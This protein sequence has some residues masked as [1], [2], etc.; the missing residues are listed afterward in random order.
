MAFSQTITTGDR[1][2]EPMIELARCSKQQ[3]IVIAGDK[4][5]E[6]MLELKNR[7]FLHVYGQANCGLPAGQ[8]DVALIDW[9]RRTFLALETALDRLAKFLGP[10]GQLVVWV[11]PQKAT[12]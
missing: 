12:A 5:V 3:R 6:L 9:R 7:G 11:D 1:I 2:V 4:S 10:A 8:Y